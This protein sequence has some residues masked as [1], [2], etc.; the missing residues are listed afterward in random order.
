MKPKVIV[1]PRIY[2]EP[3]ETLKKYCDVTV[4]EDFSE[5]NMD[6]FYEQL[7]YT[8]GI[9]TM[10]L[11]IDQYILDRAP[12]L[13]IVSNIASGYDNLDIKEFNR[14]GVMATNT[15]DVVTDTTADAA[16]ALLLA[17]A[18]RIPE[19]NNYVKSG[20]WE[21]LLVEDDLFGTDV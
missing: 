17:T 11:K 21:R 20:K 18:R 12:N 8:D 16:M 2:H 3:I 10:G 14:H 4:I 7:P 13:K 5:S 19:L 6:I 9:V 1:I 15:P